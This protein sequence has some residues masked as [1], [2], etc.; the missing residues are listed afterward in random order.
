MNFFSGDRRKL[1]KILSKIVAYQRSLP[2][3]RAVELDELQRE[4]VLSPSDI[5]FMS[6]KSVTYKPHRVSDYH[7][8]DMLHIPKEGGGCVFIGPVGRSPS[9]R[10]ARLSEFQPIVQNFLKM[11]RPRDELL[12][13]IE[14]TEHDAM[15]VAPQFIIFN[16]RSKLWRQR[17]PSLRNVA[18]E[19]GFSPFQ[20][21]EVQGSHSLTFDVS[22]DADQTA[23]MVTALL[24]RGCGFPDEVEIIYSA[25]ALDE[26]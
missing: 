6:A 24:S 12:L 20:D 11:P 3:G 14:F 17:L 13:H 8:M 10:C 22:A 23:A 4:G 1:S 26:V 21:N 25:G 9:K 19:F 18:T 7:A 2:D 15:A 5:E 16:I